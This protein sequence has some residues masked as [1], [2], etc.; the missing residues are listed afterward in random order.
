MKKKLKKEMEQDSDNWYANYQLGLINQKKGDNM[1]AIVL[2]KKALEKIGKKKSPYID[3]ANSIGLTYKR[4]GMYEKA[5]EYYNKALYTYGQH[6][7]DVIIHKKIDNIGAYESTHDLWTVMAEQI[8]RKNCALDGKKNMQI[9]AAET[10]K[11]ILNNKELIGVVIKDEGDA[12][13]IFPAYFYLF[14]S[15]LKSDL[16]FSAV[17]HNIGVV[18]AE[19]GNEAKAKEFFQESID[20]IPDGVTYQDPYISMQN[21]Q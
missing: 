19:L 8:A 3:I 11:M 14:Y 4:E 16:M 17:M 21:L 9:P 7:Y 2:F 5:R 20:F 18:Y 6:I 13:Q 1:E 15:A 12:R 10:V